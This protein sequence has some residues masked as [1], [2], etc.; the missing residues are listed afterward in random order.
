[1][2]KHFSVRVVAALAISIV[3]LL[4]VS[5]VKADEPPAW[6]FGSQLYINKVADVAESS[7]PSTFFDGGNVDCTVVDNSN[8]SID[9]PY[10]S[11]YDSSLWVGGQ[12]RPIA[13]YGNNRANFFAVPGSDTAITTSNAPVFGSYMYFT[14][15]VSASL[16]PQYVFGLPDANLS[17][18]GHLLDHFQLSRPPDRKLTDKTGANLSA[19]LSSMNFSANAQ[20]LVVTDPDIATLRVNVATGQVLPFG[21]TFTYGIG[22]NPKPKNAISSD[23]RYAV[24]ASQDAS[25]FSIY[26]LSTC[27]IVPDRISGPVQCQLRE[28]INTEFISSQIPGYSGIRYIKFLDDNTIS[29]Y[30]SYTDGAATKYAQ[31]TLSTKPG[32]ATNLQY[33][34]LGDSYISGEGAFRYLNGTDTVDNQCHVSLL[35][36]PLLAGK[37]LGYDSYHSVACS[38][39]ITNDIINTSDGYRGQAKPH[40]SKQELDKSGK[41]PSILSN[42]QQGYIDQLDFVKQYQ[43]KV[44]TISIGGNDI[45]FSARLQSCIFG[46]SCY[47]TYEDR[48]EF[49]REV[50]ATFPKLVDTYT[51][52]KNAGA[53]DAQIYVIGYP[54][55]ANTDGN[56]ALNVHM[57]HDELVFA[58]QAINYLDA[59]ISQAAAKAGV[60]YVDTQDALLGH[61]LCEAGPGSVAMNGI[62]AGND[63]PDK[64]NGPIGRESY[65][66][67]AYGHQL[68][69][70]YTLNATYNLTAPMPAADL[71]ARP[72]SETGQEILNA[73]HSGLTVRATEFDS[74]IS[75]DLAYQQTPTDVS[76]DGTNHLLPPNSALQAEIHSSPASLGAFTT[77]SVG[78]LTTQIT[79]PASVPTGYHSLHFYGTNVAGQPVDIYKVIYVAATADDLDGNGVADSTQGCVGV[80]ASGQDSD[81]DGVDDACDSDITSPPTV[82]AASEVAATVSAQS[83]LILADSD[84]ELSSP[85]NSTVASSKIS[86]SSVT[87]QTSPAAV[88]GANTSS[89]IASL[90]KEHAD[91]LRVPGSYF[92]VAGLISLSVAAVIYAVKFWWF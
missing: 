63:F 37:D 6:L 56:C 73:P 40:T 8:C 26:D 23:G 51:K 75:A 24:E 39:A 92:A 85:D 80:P 3:T 83:G 70:R 64:L 42:F 32:L 13:D 55:I 86:A 30:A 57:N 44:V 21:R 62:S 60:F 48:L 34:A 49:V 81:Q 88:L 12:W 2:H 87:T 14:G 79:I 69:E 45:G 28:L 61:R 11:V 35:S 41:M 18:E 71:S 90:S 22:I 4:G 47:S 72:P 16:T 78:N 82:V 25:T 5:L 59:V 38:G 52:I 10:G 53:A 31:Y 9:T 84:S 36:Y 65:H 77:D 17:D 29:F 91:N 7:I 50:N 15:N 68:L 89:R 54:Q 76:I 1:M 67:N 66:P 27:G 19:D 20:W 74:D 43:P 46:G 33:L 58:Q